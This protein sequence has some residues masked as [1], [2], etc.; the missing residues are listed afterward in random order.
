MN[1]IKQIRSY[2]KIARKFG[3]VVPGKELIE[4]RQSE[5]GVYVPTRVNPR[6]TKLDQIETLLG[7]IEKAT[8]WRI[9]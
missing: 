7:E 1:P 6:N 5:D 9:R 2:I 3:Q 4:M 8:K